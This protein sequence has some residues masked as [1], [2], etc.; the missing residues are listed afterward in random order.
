MPIKGTDC[1]RGNVFEE[2][3]YFDG[4]SPAL[5]VKQF[6]VVQEQNQTITLQETPNNLPSRSTIEMITCNVLKI[7][8][9]PLLGIPMLIGKIYFRHKHTLVVQQSP[10]N[11]QQNPL[12]GRVTV[13]HPSASITVGTYNL[14]FPQPALPNNQFS[15]KIGYSLD[16]SGHLYP[17]TDFRI[18]VIAKNILNADLDVVCVQEATG[19]MIH[20]LQN[21]PVGQ[22]YQFVWKG[23]T[24]HS[25]GVGILYKKDRFQLLNQSSPQLSFQVPDARR[26]GHTF[27]KKRTHVILDLKDSTTQKVHRVVSGHFPDP[28]DFPQAQKGTYVKQVIDSAAAPS[29]YAI[30]QTI[31]AGD[32]NQDEWGDLGTPKPSVGSPALATAFQPFIQQGFSADANLQS[33]EYGKAGFDNGPIFSKPRRIDWIWAK[34]ATPTHLPLNFDNRGSDHRLVAVSV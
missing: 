28:R 32:M 10:N 29:P 12:Q 9:L 20:R 4:I 27:T 23:H 22:K 24:P 17:N 31:I 5:G 13:Q 26:A 30:D 8:S 1:V 16:P 2:Y 18:G 15:T 25:H 11:T 19:D 33:S 14:L 7:I 3:F 34:G 6:D 21:S